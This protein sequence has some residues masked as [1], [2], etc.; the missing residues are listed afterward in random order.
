MRTVRRERLTG[1]ILGSL[2]LLVSLLGSGCATTENSALPISLR[3]FLEA[4]FETPPQRVAQVSLPLS[5]LS[6]PVHNLA[7]YSEGDFRQATVEEFDLGSA[8]VLT[9][10][11][12]A[13]EILMRHLSRYS[14]RRL[15]LMVGGQ[16]LAARPLDDSLRSGRLAFF[17][18]MSDA[19]LPVLVERI[20]TGLKQSQPGTQSGRS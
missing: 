13:T 15:V 7:L 9:L 19:R 2:I 12:E 20:A 6:L 8:L 3:I 1:A 4:G 18:E 5:G 14:G 17:L 10:R 11:P 16:A